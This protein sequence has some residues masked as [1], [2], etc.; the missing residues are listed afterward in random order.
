MKL[1]NYHVILSVTDKGRILDHLPLS[2]YWQV[3]YDIGTS[4]I[5][6]ITFT[7]PVKDGDGR[8]K[9]TSWEMNVDTFNNHHGFSS[10]DIRQWLKDKGWTKTKTLLLFQVSFE[11]GHLDYKFVGKVD[12]E[13]Y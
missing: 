13:Q 9:S 6:R 5:K 11:K 8:V 3:R 7:V 10:G 4:I 12:K 2:Q 1:K